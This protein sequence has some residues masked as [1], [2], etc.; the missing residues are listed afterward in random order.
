MDT[1]LR[2]WRQDALNRHQYDTAIMWA[3]KLLAMTGDDQDAF[4]LAQ[5]HCTTGNY[6]RAQALLARGG[7]AERNPQ[8]RYLHAHCAIQLDRHDD[9]LRLLGEANPTHLVALPGPASARHKLRHVDTAA[10]HPR[11]ALRS[12]RL[13]TSEER[14]GEAA[15]NLKAEAA[16]CY[17]RGV[18]YAKQNAFDRARDCYK[19]AVQ[20]DV[21]CYEAF[22]ALMANA[23]LA[24][25]DEWAFV[26]SL[27]FA[28]VSPAASPSVAQEAADFTRNL[29][30]TRLSKYARPAD[31]AHAAETLATHY[32]LA[33]NPDLVRAQADL[34]YTQCRFHD[35]LALTSSVLADDPYN[36]AILPLHLA[37]LHELGHTNAL[38]LL[39]H[40]LADTH[41]AEPATWLAVA[42][43]YYSIN[44]VADARRYFSKSSAMDALYGPAWIGFAH[45]FA[46]EGEHDQAI[47]AYS[48]AARLFQGSHLPPLF[49]GMQNLHLSNLRL[50]HEYLDAAYSLCP[51]DPL[52]LNELGVVAYHSADLPE[53]ID[54]FRTAL[55]LSARNHADPDSL[56]KLRINLAHALRRSGLY[57]DALR[58]YEQVLRHGVKDPAVLTAMGLV[59]LELDRTWDAVT[60]LHEALAVAPQDPIATD[61]LNRAL[62]AN[63]SDSAHFLLDAA[64]ARDG[65]LLLEDEVEDADFEDALRRKKDA[66]R[67]VEPNRVAGR[68]GRR[69]RHAAGFADEE[70]GVGESMMVDSDG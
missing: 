34:L 40:D 41:P 50:A 7:L 8:C 24:P 66:L 26:D 18:C 47:T 9:A 63:E 17:L 52:L 56:V 67:D 69:R 31:F 57:H 2:E 10:R 1:Q 42:T 6:A 44:K 48:T 25:A 30:T 61:V 14:D 28:A 3:D 21:Q 39:S 62:E 16:M 15:A 19:A 49:L 68:R 29:Y 35:A 53:A 51:T 12:E 58:V 37:A 54:Y 55:D 23:L 27:N 59:L 36:L 65:L 45:T 43:Y 60:A 4:W 64:A 13:P 5:V 22:D 46:A 32:N 11:P 38:F 20:I 70:S 33:T